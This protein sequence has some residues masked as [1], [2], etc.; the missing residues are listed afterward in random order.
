MSADEKSSTGERPWMNPNLGNA[1]RRGTNPFMC[2]QGA[3]PLSG[4]PLASTPGEL[5]RG[6]AVYCAWMHEGS[7]TE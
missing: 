4:V 2:S 5:V 3:A 6:R 1:V 7:L